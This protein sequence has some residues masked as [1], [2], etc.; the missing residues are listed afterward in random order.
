MREGNSKKAVFLCSI[1]NDFI[2]NEPEIT[3]EF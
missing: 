2:L 1:N 3:I